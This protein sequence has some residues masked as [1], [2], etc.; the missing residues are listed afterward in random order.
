[1]KRYLIDKI[2]FTARPHCPLRIG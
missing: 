2:G 1:M